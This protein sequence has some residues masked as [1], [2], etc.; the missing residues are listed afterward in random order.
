MQ[1]RDRPGYWFQKWVGGRRVCR[2]LATDYEQAKVEFRKLRDS[3]VPLVSTMVAAV[4]RL[5]LLSDFETWRHPKCR[6]DTAAPARL[7]LDHVMAERLKM[8]ESATKS[9]TSVS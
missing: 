8:A 6:L 1:S 9:A 4:A 3:G 2:F 5:W 7:A